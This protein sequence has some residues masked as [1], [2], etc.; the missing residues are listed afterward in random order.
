MIGGQDTDKNV[1]K[2]NTEQTKKKRE[3]HM[4]KYRIKGCYQANLRQENMKYG[5]KNR[6]RYMP[7]LKGLRRP[8][9][10]TGRITKDTPHKISTD[11]EKTYTYSITEKNQ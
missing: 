6:L 9:K 11:N 10:M 3:Y 4:K 7:G 5:I 8:S 1:E 2:N